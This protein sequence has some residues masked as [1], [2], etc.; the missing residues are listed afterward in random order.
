VQWGFI[1]VLVLAIPFILFPMTFTGTLTKGAFT[2]SFI[3]K[4]INVK[5]KAQTVVL[6][7]TKL[8]GNYN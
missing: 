1:A 2:M 5:E 7:S 8:E 6:F 4:T 3:S